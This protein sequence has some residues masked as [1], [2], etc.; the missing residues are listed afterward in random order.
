MAGSVRGARR[1][2]GAAAT[3]ASALLLAA[4]AGPLGLP[5]RADA[6]GQAQA[7][8]AA[9]A[10]A[11]AALRPQ[12]TAALAAYEADLQRLSSAVSAGVGADEWATQVQAAASAAQA[13]QVAR[14]R[15]LYMDGGPLAIWSSLLD[16]GPTGGDLVDQL[17]GVSEVLG[18]ESTSVTSFSEHAVAARSTANA[19]LAAV[20]ARVVTVSDVSAVQARLQALLDAAQARLA[21]LSA[22]AR[23]L[24]AA[25]SAAAQLDGL[26][27]AELAASSA[28]ASSAQAGRIPPSYLAL[29]K[30]AAPTCPGL[31]WHVLA[32]I[33]QVESD[34][35]RNMGPSSAGAEGPMQFLPATFAA[36]AVDGD[37]NG[38]VSIWDPADAIFTAA[39][40]LCANG[41]GAPGGLQSAIF[42]YNHADWYVAL[43]LRVAA[44]LS[45]LYPA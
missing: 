27:A 21:A 1:R 3:V 26:V 43:V 24:R 15:A 17:A 11:V 8:A 41:A 36:Y 23:S 42:A 6:A 4:L 20:A 32:A 16:P 29:Y 9:A 12:L 18:Y 31:D 28:A 7:Q 19:R 44:Q 13:Q 39:H 40:Y 33:G 22:Q 10:A 37:H 14:V 2:A 5:A 38:V 30:A 45:V 35:G 25:A 34:H